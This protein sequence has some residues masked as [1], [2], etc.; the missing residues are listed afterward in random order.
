MEHRIRVEMST[1]SNSTSAELAIS[2]EAREGR[3]GLC[4]GVPVGPRVIRCGHNFCTRC[5]TDRLEKLRVES[6]RKIGLFYNQANSAISIPQVTYSGN[7]PT[8]STGKEPEA[9]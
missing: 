7:N 2:E 5:L 3:C 8:S 1:S 9:V 4:G 6:E